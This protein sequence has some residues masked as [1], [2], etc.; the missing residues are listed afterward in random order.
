M[1]SFFVHMNN[2]RKYIGFTELFASPCV[3]VLEELALF[4]RR[5]IL[6]EVVIRCKQCRNDFYRVFSDCC[7]S[8]VALLDYFIG[9]SVE[10][11]VAFRDEGIVQSFAA[12]VNVGVGKAVTFPPLMSLNSMHR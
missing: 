12:V 5:F 8:C 6:K 2:C 7:L 1:W 3:T 9:E 10:T 11:F 4:I